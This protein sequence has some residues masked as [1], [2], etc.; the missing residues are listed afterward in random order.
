MTLPSAAKLA[1][2]NAR[3]VDLHRGQCGCRY[4][5]SCVKFEGRWYPSPDALITVLVDQRDEAR[6]VAASLDRALVAHED[7]DYDR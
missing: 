2:L 6:D 3:Q 1:L 7:G 5:C 4:P